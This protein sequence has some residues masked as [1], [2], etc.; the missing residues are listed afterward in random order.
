MNTRILLGSSAIL[1]GIGGLAA[2]FLPHEL[3][4]GLGIEPGATLPVLMQLLGALWLGFAMLNWT[5]KGNV[6]GGIYGRPVAL[7]NLAH[8]VVGAL[9]LVKA[10]MRGGAGAAVMLLVVVYA[11]YA[12]A[13]TIVFFGNP[14]PVN[15]PAAPRS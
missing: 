1:L 3:L 8:F 14:T 12:V 2:T 7:G 6:I 5:A 9:A 10:A 13:F 11:V 4:A 15:R